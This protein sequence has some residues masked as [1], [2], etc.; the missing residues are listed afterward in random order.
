MTG[1]LLDW[2]TRSDFERDVVAE[3]QAGDLAAAE[4][5]ILTACAS[6]GDA[7][8]RKACAVAVD[9]CCIEGWEQL[10]ADMIQAE[11]A[12]ELRDGSRCEAISIRLVNRNHYSELRIDRSFHA[13][14]EKRD[15]PSPEPIREAPSWSPEWQTRALICIRGLE[16][17]MEIQRAPY[18][19]GPGPK[20]ELD[21]YQRNVCLAGLMILLRFHQLIECAL[22]DPGLP[23]DV[24]A[25]VGVDLE[26]WPME[27]NTVDY[28]PAATR[29][30]RSS[31]KHDTATTDA[32]VAERAEVSRQDYENVTAQF[33]T[34]LREK[35]AALNAWP[36]WKDP[37]KRKSAIDMFRSQVKLYCADLIGV[38]TAPDWK[39]PD[40]EFEPFLRAFAEHRN[41]ATVEAA[42]KPFESDERTQLHLLFMNYALQFGGRA[43]QRQFL[44]ARGHDV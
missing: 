18:P 35:R 22:A 37:L 19:S 25:F 33:I 41:P 30:L 20:H 9:D 23:K 6:G 11:R 10:C 24:A 39:A 44:R 32:I 17:L 8:L 28:S 13:S 27:S 16:P 4:T 21:L 7:T 40:G 42:L 29:Y 15:Y 36:W 12:L 34:E 43:V 2:K 3:V 26:P 5:K 14:A 31:V 38:G 1:D